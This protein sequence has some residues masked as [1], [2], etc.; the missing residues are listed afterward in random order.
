MERL[1]KASDS[2]GL[3]VGVSR[4]DDDPTVVEG[5]GGHV[6]ARQVPRLRSRYLPTIHS[7]AIIA[8]PHRAITPR[9]GRPTGLVD[10]AAPVGD[11]HDG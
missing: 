9:R 4:D 7:G 2:Q 3:V 11:A 10:R 6:S 5:E 1:K 8:R